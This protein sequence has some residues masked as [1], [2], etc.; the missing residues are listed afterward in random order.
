M[1]IAKAL[2]GKKT[3]I[4][5]AATA[6]ASVAAASNGQLT[7]V[8]AGVAVLG[9]LLATFVRSGSKADAQKA[10]VATTAAV[11]AQLAPVIAAVTPG[12]AK[13][14]GTVG[15]IASDLSEALAPAAPAS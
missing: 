5:A 1:S 14:A 13:V 8:Q 3:Y 15:E 7:P 6:L 11:V 12:S 10:T 9:T 4:T 2:A